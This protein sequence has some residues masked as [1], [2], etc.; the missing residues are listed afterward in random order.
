M[1]INKNSKFYISPEEMVVNFKDRP[2]ANILC[3]DRFLT[4]KVKYPNRKD[5]N[6]INYYFSVIYKDM[7]DLGKGLFMYTYK[8]G[9]KNKKGDIIF[10]NF[11]FTNKEEDYASLEK[12]IEWYVTSSNSQPNESYKIIIKNEGGDGLIYNTANMM[13]L[14]RYEY[15]NQV[16]QMYSELEREKYGNG[17]WE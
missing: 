4:L 1:E 17:T 12:A 2:K 3:F 7:A 14:E 13:M 10:K 5:Y 11:C 9:I 8:F 6:Y 15:V 16:S